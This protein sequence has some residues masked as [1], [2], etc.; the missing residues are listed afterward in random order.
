MNSK[1]K[2]DENGTITIDLMRPDQIKAYLDK[3]IIGQE[4]AKKVLSIGVYNHYKKII[5]KNKMVN[6]D[7]ELD[8]SNIMLLGPTGCGK[9]LMVKTIAKLLNVPC[10]IQ[11]CTKVTASGYVGS[12]VEECL[13]GLLRSCD[14]DIEAAELGIIMLDEGDKIAKKDAGPSITR[15]VSGECVQQSLLKIVEGDVVSVPPQGG[16][17]HPEQPFLYINTENILFIMSGAFVGLEN[18]IKKRMGKNKI[19]FTAQKSVVKD[20]EEFIDYAIPQDIRDFG[21][22]PE[23]VGRFPIITNVNKLSKE[24]LIKILTEPK[25]S[26]VKQYTELMAM[27]GVKLEFTDDALDKIAELTMSLETGARGLRT[28]VETVMS[29]VMYNAPLMTNKSFTVTKEYV[30]ERT[31]FKYKNIKNVA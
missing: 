24:A 29:E 2:K 7:V 25:N 22:I 10:Y 15:D 19:G 8:K 16:R 9:T 20:D 21:M 4:E 14:Y 27:D 26:L 5:H 31:A 17:K 6:P 1:Q 12:D 28:I 3:Y 13:I 18:I 23:L 11:D 30:E